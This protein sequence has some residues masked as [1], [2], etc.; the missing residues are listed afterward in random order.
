MI[1]ECVTQTDVQAVGNLAAKAF[2]NRL[3]IKNLVT[4]FE[5]VSYICYT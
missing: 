5:I 1:L 3:T 4:E 2:V